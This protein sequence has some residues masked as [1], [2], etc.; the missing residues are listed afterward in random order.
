MKNLW[1]YDDTTKYIN[2]YVERHGMVAFEEEVP[3]LL[4]N[5]DEVAQ[6]IKVCMEEGLT[7]SQKFPSKYPI[8]LDEGE[9]I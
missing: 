3:Y 8:V 1:T 4:W 5:M 7:L 6:D 9:K 2:A